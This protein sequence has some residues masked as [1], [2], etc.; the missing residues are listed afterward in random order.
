MNDWLCPKC[1]TLN[2][3]GN[4]HC[5]NYQCKFPR[6]FNEL[7]LIDARNIYSTLINETF[8]SLIELLAWR[9]VNNMNHP[10]AISWANPNLCGKCKRVKIDHGPNAQCESCSFIGECDLYPSFDSSKA[11]LLCK[12]C[13][14]KENEAHVSAA[15]KAN[16]TI[17]EVIGSNEHETYDIIECRQQFFNAESQSIISIKQEIYA[18]DGLSEEEKRYKCAL[19]IKERVDSF[20]KTLWEITEKSTELS[21]KIRAGIVFLNNI[22]DELREKEREELKLKNINFN[23]AVNSVK[24]IKIPNVKVSKEESTIIKYAGLMKIS[25]DEARKRILGN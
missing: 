7:S 25:V 1:N 9:K 24:G 4:L 3:V 2:F 16:R 15:E 5:A 14:L 6:S 22:S 21:N 18:Q 17:S 12:E 19:A 8:P 20:K 10:F 13:I 23:P 11:I